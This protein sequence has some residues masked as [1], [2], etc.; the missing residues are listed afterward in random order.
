[1]GIN[2]VSSSGV[3]GSE[4]YFGA[5]CNSFTG[6]GLFSLQTVSVH[7]NGVLRPCV[8]H[9][10]L[11]QGSVYSIDLL[12]PPR[13]DTSIPSLRR[14]GAVGVVSP[15]QLASVDLAVHKE[16][17]VIFHFWTYRSLCDPVHEVGQFAAYVNILILALF[18]ARNMG[19]SAP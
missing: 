18:V 19:G 13:M 2:A 8:G 14:P 11:P 10:T 7:E 15:R 17:L 6:E 4:E 16:M 1:M 5:K 9:R 12:S 3:W